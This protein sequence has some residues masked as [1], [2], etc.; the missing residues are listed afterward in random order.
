MILPTGILG[1]TAADVFE[2]H[3]LAEEILQQDEVGGLRI[4]VVGAD[5]IEFLLALR[6]M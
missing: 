2:R 6:A 5:E 3:A 1:E 4:D